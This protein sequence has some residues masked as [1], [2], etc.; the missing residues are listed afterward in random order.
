MILRR[1]RR[2]I[3]TSQRPGNGLGRESFFVSSFSRERKRELIRIGIE[4]H[5][6][7]SLS[8]AVASALG[9]CLVSHQ[10]H[11][12]REGRTKEVVRK[13]TFLFSS[14]D[15]KIKKKRTMERKSDRISTGASSS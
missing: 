13:K 1:E 8:R 12:R 4:T 3:K 9:Q 2:Q 15:G 14:A 7:M 5:D 11:Q 6:A 10:K